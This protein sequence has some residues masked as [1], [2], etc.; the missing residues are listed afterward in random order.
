MALE[1]P[2]RDASGVCS[3]EGGRD[4]LD[5]AGA[6][7]KVEREMVPFDPKAPGRS[8]IGI[9]EDDPGVVVRVAIEPPHRLDRAEDRLEAHDLRG[10]AVADIAQYRAQE[11][12]G[13][14]AL[15]VVH[16][17]ER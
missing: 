13:G 6:D 4:G 7:R 14:G 11:R 8:S 5:R 10:L 15:V 9:A 3:H 1:R 16:C 17:L 2:G 12:V